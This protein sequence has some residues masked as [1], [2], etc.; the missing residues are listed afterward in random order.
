[1]S[2]IDLSELH[3]CKK[4]HGKLVCIVVDLV[5]VERCSYCNEVV[6]YTGFLRKEMGD[7]K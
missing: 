4:C 2:D 5:G 3:D 7:V 6:D 1:M